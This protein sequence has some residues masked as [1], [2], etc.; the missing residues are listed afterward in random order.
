MKL[1]LMKV[2]LFFPC[3]ILDGLVLIFIL[4]PMWI[5]CGIKVSNKEPL[6]E[7]LFE[8]TNEK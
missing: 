7:W 4:L 6:L 5:V 8:K 3:I 2:I 1:R